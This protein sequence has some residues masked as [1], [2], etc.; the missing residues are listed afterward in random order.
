MG[1]PLH[2]LA[3]LLIFSAI[4]IPLFIVK[5]PKQKDRGKLKSHK[6]LPQPPGAWPF[7]GHIW[8]LLGGH[9][10]LART[11]G[12]MA[13]RCG[14]IFSLRLGHRQTIVMS[15]WEVV[16]DCFTNQ[17]A[18]TCTRPRMAVSKYLAYDYA[19]FTNAPYGRYWREIRKISTVE[20][21]SS[22]RL[23][24][25]KHVRVS[26]VNSCLENLY[27]ECTKER[28]KG[29][30]YTKFSIG[31]WFEYLSFNIALCMIVGK[32]FSR[33]LYDKKDSFA[34]RFKKAIGTATHLA[35]IPVPSDFLPS[36][37][38]MDFLGYIGAMK[39]TQKEIDTI[40]GHWLDEHIQRRKECQGTNF[41]DCDFMDVLLSNIR[42][43][44]FTASHNK[45]TIIKA[46]A[47]V[48]FPIIP[49]C[50]ASIKRDK[51]NFNFNLN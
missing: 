38:W 50:C 21:L 20:L 1:L 43:D 4:I 7:I 35:G 2:L 25:M 6:L 24:K 30:N 36:I 13:D 16:K 29:N 12:A 34:S 47:L 19:A 37:E 5:R 32:R 22:K 39:E 15:E 45:D 17:D 40:I 42:G 49:S 41:E 27:K 18:T 31:K 11:L 46:T 23:E 26:E 9:V 3:L 44:F 33:E 14:P 28:I 8:Q 48:S 10:T 51:L